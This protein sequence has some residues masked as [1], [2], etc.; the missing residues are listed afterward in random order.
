[1]TNL[2]SRIRP[3]WCAVFALLRRAEGQT[4]VEYALILTLIALVVVAV[5]ATLGGKVSSIFSHVAS[6]L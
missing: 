1:M 3:S 4:L 6:S 5:V 2:R